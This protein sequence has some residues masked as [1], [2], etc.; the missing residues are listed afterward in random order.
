MELKVNNKKYE[1]FNGVDVTLTYDNVSSSFAYSMYFDP[2]NPDHKNLLRPL[3]Y[4]KVEIVHGNE[5]LITGRL[6]S[7]TF[8]SS[9]EPA[10]VSVSGY[11]LSGVFSDCNIPVSVYPLQ[12]DGMSLKEIAEKV[13]APF[14]IALVID[15]AVA[16]RAD[17]T[18]DSSDAKE[19]QTVAVYITELASQKKIIVSH[20]SA[21]ALLFTEAKA[22]AAPLADLSSVTKKT[23]SV[24]GQN[25][26]SSITA[27]RDA[28]ISGGNAGESEETS[29]LVKSFRP[30]TVKQT[31][32][33]D[34][35]TEDVAKMKLAAEL[36]SIKLTIEIDSWTIDNKLI[37]P[38]NT[39][40][41]KDPSIFLYNRTKWFIESVNFKGTESEQTSRLTCVLPE[42]YTGE[43]PSNPFS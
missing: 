11:S 37:K 15:S 34:T 19:S 32:G 4:Q 36:K 29:S 21:G 2:D 1:F 38:N 27:L 9:S 25:L 39:I 10:L 5:T 40:T 20:T 24:N 33:T 23:L 3:G 7:P 26:H 6:L 28:D 17:E 43:T 12:S 41:V 13:I 8:V 30:R 16:S 42:V 31:S 22:N 18:F 35:D 14:D